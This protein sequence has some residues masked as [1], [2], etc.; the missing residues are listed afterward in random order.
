[1]FSLGVNQSDNLNDISE[2]TGHIRQIEENIWK[3][4]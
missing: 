4:R 3:Y 1:M 2:D